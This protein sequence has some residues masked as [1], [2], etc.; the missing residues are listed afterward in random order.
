LVQ[1]QEAIGALSDL[2][3]G[4]FAQTASGEDIVEQVVENLKKLEAVCMNPGD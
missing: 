3:H 4:R 2:K 1:V